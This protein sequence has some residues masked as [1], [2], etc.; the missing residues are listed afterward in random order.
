[1]GTVLLA[2][3]DLTSQLAQVSLLLVCSLI[4]PAD[5]ICSQAALTAAATAPGSVGACSSAGP[6][7]AVGTECAF[8]C[9]AGHTASADKLTCGQNGQWTAPT[10]IPNT[11]GAPT[12]VVPA[13]VGACS[14]AGP[15]YAVGTECAFSCAAGHTA[16]ADK[17]TCLADGKWTTPTCTGVPMC[18]CLFV[19]L[20]M[21]A[22]MFAGL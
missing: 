15:S 9:A 2:L 4:L 8:S 18:C 3:T 13:S 17:L 7:Y 20:G 5:N 10:C 21:R 16:S 22:V 11:C 1:V 14:S 19:S 12:A 6:S